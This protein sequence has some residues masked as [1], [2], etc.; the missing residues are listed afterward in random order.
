[1]LERFQS[2]EADRGARELSADM[3]T[4]SKRV[5]D[6]WLALRCK[7]RTPGAF[8]DLIGEMEPPILYYLS[9][10][11]NDEGRAFDLLQEVWLAAYHGIGRLEDPQALRVWLYRI[12]HGLAVDR[13]RS[14]VSRERAERA[15]AET[16]ERGEEE[17]F[18]AEDAAAIHRALDELDV[19]HREVLVLH[20]LNDVSIGE[21]ASVVGC[22]EGTV[23]SR[24]YHA[25][26]AL[27]DAL[28]RGG[29]GT[30]E[31]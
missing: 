6:E 2:R 21:L 4:A 3:G 23:K 10:L 31:K 13:I 11:L 30:N 28:K 1:M 14:D 22:P 19:K 29:H 16:Q 24:I 9:K 7:L 20:F 12:A 26:R 18:D 17:S 5:R 8:E 25:K 27:K 15:W